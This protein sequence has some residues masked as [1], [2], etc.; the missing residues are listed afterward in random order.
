MASA[1]KKTGKVERT[2]TVRSKIAK[3]KAKPSVVKKVAVGSAQQDIIALVKRL[4]VDFA[5]TNLDKVLFPAQGVRKAELLAYYAS[6]AELML[7]HVTGR[8]LTLVR[9][10]SGQGSKC[11][12]QKHATEAVPSVVQRFDIHEEDGKA[13]TYMFVRDMS[14]LIA[15]AQMGVLEVHIWPCH[16]DKIERPD[17]FVFDIDPDEGLAWDRVVEAAQELRTRLSKLGLESFVKTT[18][19]KGLHVVLPVTRK[20]DWESHKAFARGVVAAMAA[21]QPKRYLINMSKKLRKGKI[22]LDYLRNG[23]GATAVA[24]Y[25]TRS[26]PQATVATPISWEELAQG[27]RPEQFT[28]S[29]LISRMEQ[30]IADPWQDYPSLRQAIS[31][32]ALRSAGVKR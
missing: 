1:P 8:P 6:V 29:S 30:P 31:S 15:L 2:S 28:I 21:D 32:A 9:C 18:G 22:F 20:L 25:S 5:L 23:R 16:A 14:G 26:H 19:G 10:P 17:Q 24:P 12:Y 4:P 13:E 27:V 3:Q 11:F 7:P